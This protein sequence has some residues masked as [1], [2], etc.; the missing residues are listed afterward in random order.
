MA[1]DISPSRTF[2]TKQKQKNIFLGLYGLF[3]L[4]LA[5]GITIYILIYLNKYSTI[6][7]IADGLLLIIM[8]MTKVYLKEQYNEV[9]HWYKGEMGE[10]ITQNII[11]NLPSTYTCVEDVKLPNGFGNIDHIVVGPNGV[12]SIET[13][14]FQPSG[15][16]W[17]K[18][19][20]YKQYVDIC[21]QTY[22]QAM[23]VKRFLEKNEVN[24]DTVI[25]I[26][27][28]AHP[29]YKTKKKTW[30]YKGVRVVPAHLLYSYINNQLNTQINMI[31]SKQ[32]T[33]LLINT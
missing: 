5:L 26:L 21:N 25:P 28:M 30:L 32:I 14:Y 15:F 33:K 11:K 29:Y 23:D 3:L 17:L 6:V 1:V 9:D 2:V 4:F 16:G 13:K 12:F 27:V 22:R 31:Q 24:I 18:R 10:S 19:L 7:W 8:F 20:P